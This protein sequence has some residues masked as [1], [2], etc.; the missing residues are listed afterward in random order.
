MTTNGIVWLIEFVYCF[1]WINILKLFYRLH[2][3]SIFLFTYFSIYKSKFIL[4]A[5]GTYVNKPTSY[6]LF[7]YTVLRQLSWAP[8]KVKGIFKLSLS[9]LDIVF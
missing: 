1:Y 6:S 5:F 4:N 7:L 3:E 2:K 9:P 8:D